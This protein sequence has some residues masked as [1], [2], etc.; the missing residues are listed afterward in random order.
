[1]KTLTN[2]DPKRE[3]LLGDRLSQ[4]GVNYTLDLNAGLTQVLSDGTNTY[5][6]GLGRIAEYQGS[7]SEYYLGDALGSVRQLTDSQGEIR[8]ATTYEPYGN[9][10]ETVG[11]AQTSYGFTGEFTDASGLVYLR[12]RYYAP[13]QGRF[14]TRDTWDGDVNTPASLNRFNYAHSN[15]VMYTDPSGN[16]IF[17]VVDTFLCALLGGVVGGTVGGFVGYHVAGGLAGWIWDTAKEG[18][19]GC[20]ETMLIL[21]TPKSQFVQE[22]KKQGAIWGAVFGFVAGTGPLGGV[23]ASLVGMGMSATQL[24]D[25]ANKLRDNFEDDCAW[26]QFGAAMVGLIGSGFGT[27]ASYR[28]GI[29][30]G[31]WIGWSSKFGSLTSKLP[32]DRPIIIVG[33]KSATRIEPLAAQLRKAGFSDVNTYQ[34][35]SFSDP[36]KIRSFTPSYPR[37]HPLDLKANYSWLYYWVKTKKAFVIDIGPG[38]AVDISLFYNLEVDML[39]NRWKYPDVIQYTP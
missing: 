13:E 28:A 37:A 26:I 6:Y 5:L 30:T 25:A 7:V 1:M 27:I 34:P 36:S 2:A 22:A 9:I 14:T 11:N 39:Y 15:P 35:K 21:A 4:N 16:C 31:Q 8:L 24:M 17:A 38:D 29:S 18:R 32:K 12:A 3:N 10:A 19:C 33:R 23:A 20:A